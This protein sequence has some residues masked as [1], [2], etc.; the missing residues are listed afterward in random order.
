MNVQV[1]FG[2][3]HHTF[4]LVYAD[5][6]TH[7]P[8]FALWPALPA[9]DYYGGSVALGVA[10]FRRSRVPHAADVQDGLGALF[11]SLRLL[12][13]VLRKPRSATARDR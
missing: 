3:P 13:A 5:A 10:P 11:V 9:A 8:P 4:P 12:E 2:F 7:L 1:D 6:R